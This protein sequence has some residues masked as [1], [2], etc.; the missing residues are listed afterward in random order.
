MN[1]ASL[2]GYY[3]EIQKTHY[4]M[5]FS[6]LV[7]TGPRHDADQ[8]NVKQPS[9]QRFA[10][11]ASFL[12]NLSPRPHIPGGGGTPIYQPFWY[13]PPKRVS[14]SSIF[15]RNCVLVLRWGGKNGK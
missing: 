14:F 2:L 7:E 12:S 9:Y 11:G 5:F 13:V 4:S 3:R 1:D 8:G 10:T 6:S 15:S